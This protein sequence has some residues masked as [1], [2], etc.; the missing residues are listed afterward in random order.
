MSGECRKPRTGI[1]RQAARDSAIELK[2]IGDRLDG[3]PTQGMQVG[4]ELEITKIPAITCHQIRRTF[5]CSGPSVFSAIA[6]VRRKSGSA[7]P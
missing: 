6:R 5:G 1:G 3:K 2:E 7:S 4:G